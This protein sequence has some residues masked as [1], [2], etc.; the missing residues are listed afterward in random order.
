MEGK[1]NLQGSYG[2][3]GIVECLKIIDGCNLKQFEV[4]FEGAYRPTENVFFSFSA[5]NENADENEIPFWPKN[6]NESY[7]CLYHR[8]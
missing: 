8:T 2:L 4:T 1:T 6:D 7:L 5:I 3:S